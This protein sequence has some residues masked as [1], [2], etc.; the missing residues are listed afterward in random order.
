MRVAEIKMKESGE[1]TDSRPVS[2][3]GIPS[4]NYI[5]INLTK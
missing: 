3:F 5:K 1:A 2:A 4:I